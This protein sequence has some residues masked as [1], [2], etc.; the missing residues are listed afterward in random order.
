M[1]TDN[2]LDL[3]QQYADDLVL[4]DRFIHHTLNNQEVKLETNNLKTTTYRGTSE[5][6]SIQEGLLAVARL[7]PEI[8]LV[9]IEVRQTTSYWES[10]QRALLQ[11]S[12]FPVSER[13]LNEC[14][15]YQ[16]REVP[17]GYLVNFTQ[18]KN[19]WQLWTWQAQQR[20]TELGLSLK[21]LIPYWGVWHPVRDI[22]AAGD[23]LTIK[24]LGRQF[25][26]EITKPII[27]LKKQPNSDLQA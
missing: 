15:S 14:L 20:R 24:V 12:F 19:L 22:Q 26:V 21:L 25:T 13:V 6:Y 18:A 17:A 16:F 7:T 11:V 10:I 9:T 4:I 2:L 23:T 27:W 8:D 1:H 5:I 3:Y